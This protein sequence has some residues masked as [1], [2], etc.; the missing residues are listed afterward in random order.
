MGGSRKTTLAKELFNRIFSSFDRCSFV[1]DVRDAA[2]RKLLKDLGADHL[3][4]DSVDEGL[5]SSHAR[6]LFCWHAFM[7]P[8]PPAE[9]ETLVEEFLKA[10]NGLPLSLKLLGAQL[11]G[12]KSKVYWESQLDKISRILPGDIRK[13]LHVSYDVLDEEEKEMFLD[14][15]RNIKFENK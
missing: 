2:C 15:E 1:S 5:D 8:C 4:F 6:Q 12:R 11:Y 9:L 3:S 13:R 10:C 14:V 7:Q